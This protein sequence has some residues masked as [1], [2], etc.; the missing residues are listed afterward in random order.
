MSKLKIAT[1]INIDLEFEIAP[2]L[3]RL[4]AWAIDFVLF[5]IYF[6]IMLKL[7]STLPNIISAENEYWMFIIIMLPI[8]VYHVVT[9]FL[10]NGQT[11]GKKAVGIKVIN[12]SGGNATFSQYIIRWMLRISD[13]LLFYM[14]VLTIAFGGSVLMQMA[15]VSLLA[16][17]DIFCIVLTK[18]GQ[19]IGD[20]AANTILIDLKNK[21]SLTDT[22]FMELDD[23]YIPTY[24][25]V[26][27]LSDRDINMIKNIY[28]GLQ[29]KH[30]EQLANRTASKIMQVLNITSNDE[31]YF[32]LETLL[33]DYNHLSTR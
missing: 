5:I 29:K 26:M 15:F 33:K 31:P 21:S 11:L 6:F 14:I 17:A 25:A 9:E 32:F 13:L 4:L 27:Q 23:D 18:K 24:P 28:K 3:K 8:A 7:L 1:S 16:I 19:R 10:M 12:E 30:N 2:F 22:V 20:M